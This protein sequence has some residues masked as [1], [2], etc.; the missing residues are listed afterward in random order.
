MIKWLKK[1]I[2]FIISFFTC[3][4]E[5]QEEKIENS[6]L[7]PLEITNIKVNKYQDDNFHLK[8]YFNLDDKDEIETIL[9][10]VKG[11]KKETGYIQCSHLTYDE[12]TKI[13]PLEGS[14]LPAV[15]EL[16]PQNN[17]LNLNYEAPFF[18][19]VDMISKELDLDVQLIAKK[20]DYCFMGDSEIKKIHIEV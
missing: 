6:Y 9:V 17:C 12:P 7:I 3:K 16:K 4:K 2:N 13:Q 14:R 11:D 15:F 19:L 20:G 8:I 10:K 1:I 18:I 5:T